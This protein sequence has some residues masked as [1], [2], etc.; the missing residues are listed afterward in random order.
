MKVENKSSIVSFVL[1]AAFGVFVLCLLAGCSESYDSMLD[2][3]NKK[4]I[5]MSSI[6]PAVK[7]G[8]V[9]FDQ[10]GMLENIYIADVWSTLNIKGPEGCKS[11]LWSIEN[12]KGEQKFTSTEKNFSCFFYESVIFKPGFWTLRLVV[13][14]SDDQEYS[15]TAILNIK[16]HF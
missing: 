2:N 16:S 3:Y 7:P 8:Q 14:G 4:F 5:P 6:P 15:D 13:I 10:D 1:G 9:G 12:S 11:Y